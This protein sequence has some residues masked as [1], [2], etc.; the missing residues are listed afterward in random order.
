MSCDYAIKCLDCGE[1]HNFSDANHRLEA[2]RAL[3]EHRAAVAALAPLLADPR[4]SSITLSLDYQGSF[5]EPAWFEKHAS[6]RLAPIDEYGVV[7]DAQQPCQRCGTFDNLEFVTFRSGPSFL[8][9]T[10]IRDF[11]YPPKSR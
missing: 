10:C 5:I 4:G 7:Y 9:K 11:L 8:C 1:E 2:M 6:C 3:I